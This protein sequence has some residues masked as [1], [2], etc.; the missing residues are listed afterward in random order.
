MTSERAAERT[1]II[2]QVHSISCTGHQT[3]ITNCVQSAEFVGSQ[4]LVHEMDRHELDCTKTT[5]NATDKLIYRCPQVLVILNILP[6]RH[7]K[8]NQHDLMAHAIKSTRR[9]HTKSHTNFADPL[10]VLRQE[11]LEGMEFLGNTF[12][13]IQTINPHNNFDSVKALLQLS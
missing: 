8:L 5:V 10:R 11:E 13:V 1:D 4:T 6:R 3:D 7:S 2:Y 9:N 12:D